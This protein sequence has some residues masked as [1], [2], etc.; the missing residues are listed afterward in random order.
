MTYKKWKRDRHDSSVSVSE[1]AY[2]A[3][4][5]RVFI[6]NRGGAWDVQAASKG[7]LS[8]AR[9]FSAMSGLMK[10][11]IVCGVIGLLLFILMQF[12]WLSQQ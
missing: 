10:G 12:G 3:T 7:T 2:F 11:M 9:E 5:P 8:H 1:L 4:K 6:E